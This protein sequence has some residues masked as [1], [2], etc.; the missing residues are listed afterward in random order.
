LG[1]IICKD[2]IKVDMVNIKVILK[3]KPLIN[4][5]K[6]KIFLGNTRYHIKFIIHYSDITFPI[7]ELLKK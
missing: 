4:Q 5:M 7:D 6:I 3:L 1:H 2:R